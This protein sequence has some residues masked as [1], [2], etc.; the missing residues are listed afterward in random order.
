MALIFSLICARINCRINNQDVGD[1]RRH[2]AHYDVTVMKHWYMC[3]KVFIY[4]CVCIC[5]TI[6]SSA[7]IP[8]LAMMR[9]HQK[10]RI[11]FRNDVVM[12]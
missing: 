10:L 6:Y 5:V 9:M 3:A 7:F 1:L 11:S 12:T 8:V 2:R 4:M